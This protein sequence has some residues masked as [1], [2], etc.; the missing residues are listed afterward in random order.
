MDIREILRQIQQGQSNRAVE[1]NT[2]IHRKTVAR[3][4][5]WAKEQGLLEGPLP[6]L[7]EVQRMLEE[8]W[9]RPAPPQQIEQRHDRTPGATSS[10]GLSR[11]GTRHRLLL[12]LRIS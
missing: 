6:S 4:R 12:A 7:S 5:A 3:Y 2:G 11:S 9:Q 1:R 10:D 8:T